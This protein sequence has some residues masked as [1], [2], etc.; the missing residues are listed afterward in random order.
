MMFFFVCAELKND[1][2]LLLRNGYNIEGVLD[3]S[4]MFN[5]MYSPRSMVGANSAF[6]GVF[7]K[8]LKFASSDGNSDVVINGVNENGDIDISSSLFTV[9]VLK[10]TTDDD[11]LPA[12]VGDLVR[13]TYDG[14]I[15][16]GY[17]DDVSC[18]YGQYDG[19]KYKLL[20]K[21]IE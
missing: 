10:V 15:Y 18:K 16:L 8:K 17:I 14:N 13:T 5:A 9:G 21:S 2:Y 4:L 7:A 19:M 6:I 3:S 1:K 20:V 11:A 12:D